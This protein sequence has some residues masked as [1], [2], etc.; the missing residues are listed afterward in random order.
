M[1]TLF[2]FSYLIVGMMYLFIGI[3]PLTV[4]NV[5]QIPIKGIIIS[6]ESKGVFGQEITSS[7]KIVEFIEKADK[8]PSVKAIIFEINSPGGTPVASKEIVTAIKK[9]NKLTVS[10]IRDIGTSGA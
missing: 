9:T 1:L 2:I 5:V 6:D 3:E 4:G 8:T 10:Y 7:T